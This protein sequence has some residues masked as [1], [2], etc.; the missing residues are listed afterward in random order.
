M[1]YTKFVAKAEALGFHVEVTTLRGLLL[2]LEVTD[3][4]GDFMATIDGMYAYNYNF[5]CGWR[6]ETAH[7]TY[8]AYR[9][10]VLLVQQ[11]A[12]TEVKNRGTLP[13]GVATSHF[14]EIW[15]QR[16]SVQ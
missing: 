5:G 12:N 1:K 16:V 13:D 10:L 4:A 8:K 2:R 9:C 11:L 14:D 7:C 6:P 15:K 3:K